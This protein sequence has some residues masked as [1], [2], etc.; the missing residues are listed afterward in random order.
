LVRR[1]PAF[2]PP[3]WHHH[4]CGRGE[5]VD[6]P[7]LGSGSSE[8]GFDSCLGHHRSRSRRQAVKASVLHADTRS[9]DP[10]REHQKGDSQLAHPE[11]ESR[12]ALL[13]PHSSDAPRSLRQARP[14]ALAHRVWGHRDL[15][16]C[17]LQRRGHRSLGQGA[18]VGHHTDRPEQTASVAQRKSTSVTSRRPLVQS[19]PDAPI[20]SPV[21]QWQSNRLISDRRVF[22]SRREDQYAKAIRFLHPDTPNMQRRAKKCRRK[23]LACTARAGSSQ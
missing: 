6:A 10:S 7:D 19:Q 21:A 12:H 14:A 22:D 18:W 23:P 20:H 13:W 5:T 4:Q 1:Q 15:D 11:L 17:S 16:L 2:D 3:S 9:F 8:C